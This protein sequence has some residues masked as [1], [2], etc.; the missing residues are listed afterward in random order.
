MMS[1]NFYAMAAAGTR[2]LDSPG[3]NNLYFIGVAGGVAISLLLTVVVIMV[4]IRRYYHKSKRANVPLELNEHIYDTPDSYDIRPSLPPRP[5]KLQRTD[6]LLHSVDTKQL[7]DHSIEDTQNCAK[8][9]KNWEDELKETNCDHTQPTDDNC[10][11]KLLVNDNSEGNASPST[12]VQINGTPMPVLDHACTEHTEE[13]CNPPFPKSS[14]FP[15]FSVLSSGQTSV[16]E[17]IHGY[18]KMQHYEQ[19]Q[20]YEKIRHCDINIDEIQVE[21]VTN[22][23]PTCALTKQIAGTR[24]DTQSQHHLLVADCCHECKALD[25]ENSLMARTDQEIENIT[26]NDL[27]SALDSASVQIESPIPVNINENDG[28]QKNGTGTCFEGS[29]SNSGGY[30]RI[31]HY[32]RIE[33]CDLNFAQI[34]SPAITEDVVNTT[35]SE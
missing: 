28:L 13:L 21:N 16:Y 20:R 12:P 32:E 11:H 31:C 18:E 6:Q 24:E 7:R 2:Q 10:C 1:L 19:I 33:H 4:T 35:S 9:E 14:N 17:Q 5:S 3:S 22:P 8:I 23:A 26:E 27:N 30:E 34:L 29:N 15:A 25:L